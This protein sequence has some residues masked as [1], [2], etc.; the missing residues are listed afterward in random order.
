MTGG[1]RERLSPGFPPPQAVILVNGCVNCLCVAFMISAACKPHS[2]WGL[3]DDIAGAAVTSSDMAAFW[4]HTF[5]LRV[6]W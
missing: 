1:A 2:N 6:L 4:S 3:G 5:Q